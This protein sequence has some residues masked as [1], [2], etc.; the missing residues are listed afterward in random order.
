VVVAGGFGS[1]IDPHSACEI[2][3][4]PP[5]LE[6]RIE[7][8]GNT[9][10]EGAMLYLLSSRARDRIDNISSFLSYLELSDSSFFMEKYIEKMMF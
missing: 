6:D 3:L 7:I 9:A 10:G 1:H 5:E 2:G 4:F 8:V